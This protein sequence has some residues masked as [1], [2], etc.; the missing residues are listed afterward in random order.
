MMEDVF[1]QIPP[2]RRELLS[3]HDKVIKQVAHRTW[4]H[5]EE[6]CRQGDMKSTRAGIKRA[7]S[8]DRSMLF[9]TRVAALWL[10]SFF[11]YDW[12]QKTQAMKKS[13]KGS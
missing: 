3:L 6:L 8:I 13:V 11:G 5:A 1:K 4:C 10:A 12:F 2:E 7:V 9:E